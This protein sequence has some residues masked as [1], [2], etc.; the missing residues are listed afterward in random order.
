VRALRAGAEIEELELASQFRCNGSDGYLAWLDFSNVDVTT[1]RIFDEA[2][3]A[4]VPGPD[5][6][7][8]AYD[9]WARLNFGTSKE[10]ITEGLERIARIL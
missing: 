9:R 5:M 2:K 7:G 1:A 4:L 3:V 10:I 6:G 8:E